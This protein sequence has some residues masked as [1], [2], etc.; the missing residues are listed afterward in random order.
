MAGRRS[1]LQ[2]IGDRD[3]CFC[4]DFQMSNESVLKSANL[5]YLL[6]K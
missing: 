3:A 1:I 4:I 2:L 5:D 6:I